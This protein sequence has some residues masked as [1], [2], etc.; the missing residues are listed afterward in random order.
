ME[1]LSGG[2]LLYEISESLLQFKPFKTLRELPY[3]CWIFSLVASQLGYY[4]DINL[5]T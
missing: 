3:F 5:E 4:D 1:N 2:V